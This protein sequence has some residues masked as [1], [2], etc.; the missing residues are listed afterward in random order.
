MPTLLIKLRLSAKELPQ[1]SGTILGLG[2]VSCFQIHLKQIHVG[3]Y[4]I[5]FHLIN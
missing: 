4:R 2:N 5:Q 1:T 3:F